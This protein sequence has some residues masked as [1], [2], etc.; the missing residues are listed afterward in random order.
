M[1][2]DPKALFNY[3]IGLEGIRAALASANANSPKGAIET[4]TRHYQLYANDQG[5]GGG[6]LPGPRGGYRNGAAVRLTDVGTSR[7][8]WRTG[9]T[10]ASS[11]VSRA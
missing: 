7:I 3:G 5:P 2:L 9:A 10:S 11:T 1:A 8:R 6:R 4:A